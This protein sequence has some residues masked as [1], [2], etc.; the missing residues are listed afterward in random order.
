MVL[1]HYGRVKVSL[2]LGYTDT[3][4]VLATITLCL[5]RDDELMCIQREEAILCIR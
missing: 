2:R 5:D 4:A 1:A 3:V